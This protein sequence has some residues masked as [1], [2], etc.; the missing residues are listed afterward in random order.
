MSD[1]VEECRREWRRLGV[2]GA[3]AEEMAADLA[4]DLGDAEA[5]GISAEEFLGTEPR[6][7]AAAWAAERGIVPSPSPPRRPR[8]LAAFTVLASIAVVVAAV[9][10]ATG[11]PKVSLVQ[12]K[13]TAT[14]PI[15]SVRPTVRHVV[16]TASAA[17]PVEWILLLVAVAALG[18]AVWQWSRSLGA[19]SRPA[20]HR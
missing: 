9:L 8:F 1:F 10:L 11:E 5:E 6:A 3:L 20:A 18:F 2:P 15:G 17:A 14:P 16:A 13:K 4:S 7:F 12:T 19:W